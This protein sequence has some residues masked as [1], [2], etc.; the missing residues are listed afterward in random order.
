[1]TPTEIQKLM[2]ADTSHL[3]SLRPTDYAREAIRGIESDMQAMHQAARAAA[4]RREKAELA[5]IELNERTKR[6]NQI[7]EEQNQQLKKE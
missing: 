6:Q 2:T 3:H 4:E 1:M 7:L 5:T